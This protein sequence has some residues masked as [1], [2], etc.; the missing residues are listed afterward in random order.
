MRTTCMV[1]HNSLRLM[2]IMEWGLY[3]RLRISVSHTFSSRRISCGIKIKY[4][5]VRQRM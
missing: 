4:T 2:K 5:S 1:R 3:Y